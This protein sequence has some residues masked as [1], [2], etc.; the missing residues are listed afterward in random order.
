MRSPS[1]DGPVLLCVRRD[2]FSG[3]PVLSSGGRLSVVVERSGHL[4]VNLRLGD[5]VLR[6]SV[7]FGVI[8]ELVL[9]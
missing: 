8:V 6:E 3:V 2:V 9:G 5:R 4:L 1:V 7:D